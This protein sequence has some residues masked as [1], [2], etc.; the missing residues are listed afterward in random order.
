[1]K[2]IGVFFGSGSVEHDISIITANLIINGLKGLGYSVVPVYITKQGKLML[3]EELGN[4]KLFSDP[5]KKV[6]DESSFAEYYLDMQE[7]VGKMVFKK[8]GILGKSITVD[9]AFP[10]LHGTYGEDGTIQGLF[11]MFGL[12]YVGCGVPASAISMDKVLTLS[13]RQYLKLAYW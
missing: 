7:S 10:A 8:K 5:N 3:G 6:E 2:S 11:E 1:M 13:H 12:P 4:L 9:L